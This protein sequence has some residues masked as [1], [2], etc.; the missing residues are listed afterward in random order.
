MFQKFACIH[1]TTTRQWI[2]TLLCCTWDRVSITVT[3][4][5]LYVFRALVG[6]SPPEHSASSAGGAKSASPVRYR[7]NCVLPESLLLIVKVARKCTNKTR[8]HRAWFV[9]A[10]NRAGL[11]V[12]K[13]IVEARLCAW[14]MARSYWLVPRAGALDAPIKGS[15]ACTRTSFPSGRGSTRSWRRSGAFLNRY[16]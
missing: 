7:I 12:A 8:S 2:T 15:L 10:M 9:Q 14:K 3:L 6:I 1:S 13:V 11:T 16:F 5:V 4:W